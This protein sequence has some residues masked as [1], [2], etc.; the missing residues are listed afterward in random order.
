MKKLVFLFLAVV[1]LAGCGV[2][3]Q[4]RRC[5]ALNC[6]QVIKD[7]TRIKDS[8]YLVPIP[9]DVNADTAWLY[10]WLS[11][12][13][14]NEVVMKNYSITNGKYIRLQQDVESGKFSVYSY[15][16]ARH[17]TVYGASTVHTEYKEIIQN[18]PPTNILTKSQ[19][20]MVTAFWPCAIGSALLILLIAYLIYRR[21]K[22]GLT[23]LLDLHI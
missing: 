3:Y 9:Y 8:T 13:S 14:L 16:P 22:K 23:N 2:N 20:F 7:S 19:R 12:D 18:V 15:L 6:G 5:R 10:A 1:L 17:D 11:C 21:V 4:A